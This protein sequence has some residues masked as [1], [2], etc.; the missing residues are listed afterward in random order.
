MRDRKRVREN[1][2]AGVRVR[3]W[4]RESEGFRKRERESNNRVS[5]PSFL[6]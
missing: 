4:E 3:E 6:R 5:C 1:E 2:R